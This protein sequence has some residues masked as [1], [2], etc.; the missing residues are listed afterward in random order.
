M[1]IDEIISIPSSVEHPLMSFQ[2]YF[3][4]AELE[5]ISN[6]MFFA[7]A[8]NGSDLSFLGILDENK[9]VLSIIHL[10]KEDTPYFQITYTNTA[11]EFQRQGLFRFLMNKAVDL[12]GSILSDDAQSD[13]AKMAWLSLIKRPS[14]LQI[15]IYDTEHGKLL[16]LP[17]DLDSIWNGKTTPVLVAYK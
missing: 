6:N 5:Q 16:P 4:F 7:E 9:N 3:K 8:G 14:G 12:Y 10:E 1:K 2:R 17:D 13:K 11:A 15:G